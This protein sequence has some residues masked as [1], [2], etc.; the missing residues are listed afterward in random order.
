MND[1]PSVIPLEAEVIMDNQN[2]PQ[3]R[4]APPEARPLLTSRALLI[5]LTAVLAAVAVALKPAVALPVGVGV[6]VVTLLVKILDD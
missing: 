2:G 5:I 4:S 3:S 6:A 1:E